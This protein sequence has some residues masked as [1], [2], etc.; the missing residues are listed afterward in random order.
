MT[1][2]DF[3]TMLLCHII[4]KFISEYLYSQFKWLPC[5]DIWNNLETD[6]HECAGIPEEVKL[7]KDRMTETNTV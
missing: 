2:I 1:S 5:Y 4:R 3:T 7:L 6:I